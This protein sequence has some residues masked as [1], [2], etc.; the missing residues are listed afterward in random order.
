MEAK[1]ILEQF[2]L[3]DKKAEIYLACLEL[4]PATATQIAKRVGIARSSFYE[5]AEYL[6]NRGLLVQSKKEKK[7]IFSALNPELLKAE[8]QE[9]LNKLEEIL[10][11]LKSIYK[12]TGAKPKIYFYEGLEGINKIHKDTLKYKGEQISF[13]TEQFLA[14]KEKQFSREYIK[15]RVKNK[16]KARVIGPVSND[17]INIKKKDNRELRQTKMI[18]KDLYDSNVEFLIYGNKVAIINYKENF[19]FIIESSDV[20]NPL[21][22]VFELIWR[23]GFVLE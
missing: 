11:Q 13:S 2:N 7:R 12:T 16:I 22:M 8:Q 14:A 23:G 1:K 18:P 6:I 9:K 10:P 4:G 3:K 19:G 5:I 17:F 15:N 20:A 21:K